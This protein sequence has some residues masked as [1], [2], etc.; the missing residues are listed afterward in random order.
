M[1]ASRR[2]AGWIL[3]VRDLERGSRATRHR[4]EQ[5]EQGPTFQKVHHPSRT[6]AGLAAGGRAMFAADQSNPYGP[7]PSQTHN[8]PTTALPARPPTSRTLIFGID[9]SHPS[10]ACPRSRINTD[11]DR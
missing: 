8:E 10:C 5:N 2:C 4:Y 7:H 3:P 6:A 11:T 1:S 9:T